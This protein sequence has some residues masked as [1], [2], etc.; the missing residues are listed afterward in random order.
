M[1]KIFQPEDEA[2]RKELMQK[3]AA[4]TVRR[5]VGRVMRPPMPPGGQRLRR[6]PGDQGPGQWRPQGPPGG[7]NTPENF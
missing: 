7:G 1:A 5:M 6:R 3:L 2:E 4:E